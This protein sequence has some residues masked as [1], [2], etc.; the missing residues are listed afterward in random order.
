MAIRASGEIA[1]TLAESLI[2]GWDITCAHHLTGR[3]FPDFGDPVR[4][5]RRNAGE[6]GIVCLSGLGGMGRNA[7]LPPDCIDCY[8]LCFLVVAEY[9]F[10]HLAVAHIAEQMSS[11][12][13]N[14]LQRRLQYLCQAVV[15]LC[16]R[17]IRREQDGVDRLTTAVMTSEHMVQKIICRS[18]G[19]ISKRKRGILAGATADRSTKSA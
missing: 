12:I 15:L 17:L 1:E 7:P 5:V 8:P 9:A 3:A 16:T 14:Q 19:A 10:I 11:M 2:S 6:N 13:V 4:T 18:S